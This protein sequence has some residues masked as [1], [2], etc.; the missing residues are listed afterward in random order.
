MAKFFQK[1]RTIHDENKLEIV[2]DKSPF[3]YV[4]AYKT[5]RTNMNFLS[6][7][8]QYKKLLLTSSIPGEGKSSVSINLARVLAENGKRVLLI[9]CDMRKPMLHR[10]LRAQRFRSRGL[11]TV[12]SGNSTLEES[13]ATFSDLQFD[14]M[15][16]GPIPPNPT[17]LLA[18]AEMGN[19]LELLETR[20]D[21][22]ICD[23][24]PVSLVTDAAIL[25]EYCDGVLLVVRQKYATFQQVKR[26]KQNLQ[27]VHAQ[28]LGCVLNQYDVSK[29]VRES[30]GS[31]YYHYQYGDTKLASDGMMQ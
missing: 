6:R 10:Y 9:D 11:S 7:N 15:T 18:S 23:T 19:L 2:S 28:I 27:N 12:L 5:L 16:A 3:A 31:A 13:I 22:I 4:E 17:E 29:N 8:S 24:P 1:N 26:A 14:L 21:Y 30:A 20:Y 25:S